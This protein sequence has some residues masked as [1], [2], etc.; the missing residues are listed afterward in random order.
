MIY[1]LGNNH[2]IKNV[3]H[4]DVYLLGGVEK[5]SFRRKMAAHIPITKEETKYKK[6]ETTKMSMGILNLISL[7]L[8]NFLGNI[9]EFELFSNF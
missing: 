7:H 2:V 3:M 5:A 8:G 4:F 9:S 6:I 1:L